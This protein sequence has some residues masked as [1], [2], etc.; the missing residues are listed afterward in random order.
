MVEVRFEGD[1]HT[2][3]R[4][5][6][7]NPSKLARFFMAVS[8]GMIKNERQAILAQVILV[9]VLFILAGIF[10]ANSNDTTI[11]QPSKELI[12]RPKP[13]GPIN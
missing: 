9:V 7:Q 13:I 5:L 4:T 8:F 11:Q 1:Y 3:P 10:F 6:N 12:E 2:A